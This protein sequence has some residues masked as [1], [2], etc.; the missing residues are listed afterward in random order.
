LVK[1]KVKEL[2]TVQNWIKNGPLVMDGAMGTELIDLGLQV[3]DCPHRWNI[4]RW[5]DVR[6]VHKSYVE[7]GADIILTNT[8]GANEYRLSLFGLDHEVYELN[9]SGV[10][11]AKDIGD[12]PYLIAGD[13]GPT[14]YLLAPYGDFSP[15]DFVRC[16]YQQAVALDEANVDLFVVETQSDPREAVAAIKG[17]RKAS[18]KPIIVTF[19][20]SYGKNG[21]RTVMGTSPDEALK[22]LLGKDIQGFGV[23]CG[24]GLEQYI[25]LVKMVRKMTTLPLMAKPNA[26]RPELIRGEVRYNETPDD[27]RR[28]IPELLAAGA[29]FVGGCCGTTPAHIKVI[30]EAVDEYNS[31]RSRRNS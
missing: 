15:S 30:R 20:F 16:F 26:G 12:R 24:E 14:G 7:A 5:E 10:E 8:F 19:S 27:F 23:N 13:I 17:I 28:M 3:T 1:T 2:I 9:H 11:V 6:A 25:E 18:T 29:D 21:Y 22:A 4:E 31:T